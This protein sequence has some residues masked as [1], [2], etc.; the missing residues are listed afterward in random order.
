MTPTEV[1]LTL[2]AIANDSRKVED[3]FRERTRDSCN[4]R[5]DIQRRIKDVQSQCNHEWSE[6]KYEDVENWTQ[7]CNVCYLE[8]WNHNGYPDVS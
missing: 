1:K 7:T 5:D 8:R 6:V 2:Q 4:K 3:E